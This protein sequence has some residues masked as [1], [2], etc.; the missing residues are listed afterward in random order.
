MGTLST[1]KSKLPSLSKGQKQIASFILTHSEKAAYMTAHALGTN[2]GVSESTVVRFANELGFEG[3]P[4]LQHA[5]REEIRSK[6]TALQRIELA[7]TR[8]PK[9]SLATNVLLSDA[10]KIK[11]TAELLDKTAFDAAT[12]ALLRADKIY[13][14]AVRSSAPLA[15]FMSF[16]L[17]LLFDNVVLVQTTSGSEMFEQLL[18]M[19]PKDVA[20]GISFPR[21]STRVIHAMDYARSC[22]ASTVAITDSSD[23]PIAKLSDYALLARSDMVSFVDSLVAPLSLINA[24]VVALGNKM[25]PE[26]EEKFKK[27]EDIWDEYNVYAKN[28]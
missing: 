22:G 21:Y 20:V 13:I 7:N 5:L 1:I 19:T 17:R 27:L 4:E 24:L 15:S 12:D 16:Y 6:L 28:S 3:Y 23:S 26:A 8:I 9:D 14:L 10:E 18:H 11:S 2:V 25:G